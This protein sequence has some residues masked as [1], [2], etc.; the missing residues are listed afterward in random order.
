MPAQWSTFLAPAPRTEA[1]REPSSLL[2]RPG[3]WASC[4]EAKAI[5][6]TCLAT[7]RRRC[8]RTASHHHLA[9]R[10]RRTGCAA[11]AKSPRRTQRQCRRR[12]EHDLVDLESR[13]RVVPQ[14]FDVSL[15]GPYLAR[16]SVQ[17]GE[18]RRE[19]RLQE[20]PGTLRNA[21]MKRTFK[22]IRVS[23]SS[24]AVLPTVRTSI[25]GPR[26]Y[27]GLVV[28]G[29]RIIRVRMCP[30]WVARIG[31]DGLDDRIR[32]RRYNRHLLPAGLCCP[33]VSP[34]RPA[35]PVTRRGGGRRLSSVLAMSPLS[36]RASDHLDRT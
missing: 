31:E 6:V 5:N 4:D 13:E 30:V 23:I 9:R 24:R 15:L 17:V 29:H 20:L 19:D 14:V 25:V 1:R 26:Q 27:A 18:R 2:A 22:P 33:P 21:S 3:H 16:V 7:A 11:P 36:H 10:C 8:A 32:C 12:H 34:E 28:S 35:L